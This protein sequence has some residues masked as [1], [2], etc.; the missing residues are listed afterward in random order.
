[1][2]DGVLRHGNVLYNI[3]GVSRELTI[4]DAWR[5][6]RLADVDRDIEAMPMGL[7]TPLGAG[8]AVSGGQ[9]QRIGI[10]TVAGLAPLLLEQGAQADF[11]KPMAIPLAFGVL[12]ATTVTLVL[13]PAAYLVLDDIE[14]LLRRLFRPPDAAR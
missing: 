10:T 1:M 11:L 12:F 5:A 3:I 13:V 7:F 2:Q 6:A 9:A 4:D 14:R 8:G